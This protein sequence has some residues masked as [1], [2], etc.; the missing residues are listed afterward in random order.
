MIHSGCYD[1]EEELERDG[2]KK[3]RK[4]S[5]HAL[6]EQFQVVLFLLI[7]AIPLY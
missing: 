2:T 7:L 4:R 6:I 5:S 1:Y 3:I